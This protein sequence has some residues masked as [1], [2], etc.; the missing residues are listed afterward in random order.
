MVWNVTS[1]MLSLD[2]PV[3]A[4]R[5]L[6]LVVLPSPEAPQFGPLTASYLISLDIAA[7]GTLLDQTAVPELA[8]QVNGLSVTAGA[9]V[10]AGGT[11][12]WDF[13]G[14][15]GF[16]SEDQHSYAQPGK[17]DVGLRLVLDGR[18]AEYAGSIVVSRE[19]VV[20]A[21]LT[22]FPTFEAIDD[23]SVPAGFTRVRC[24]SNAEAGET[25]AVIWQRAGQSPI[26]GQ[27]VEFDLPPGRHTIAFAATRE[28]TARIYSQ[29]RFAPDDTLAMSALRLATN[30]VFELDGTETTGAQGNDPA[31]ELVTH[32]FGD[33]SISPVDRWTLELSLEDNEFLRSVSI[34]DN[35]QVDLDE[36]EDALLVLEYETL[37]T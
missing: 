3:G 32:L 12:L 13:G 28:L 16:R 34:N 9:T 29:Q 7:D 18:L 19:Q 36:I 2:A 5:N 14:G 15:D 27:Q 4:L 23:P 1:P 8:F 30:R 6:G 11:R 20:S 21:P 17:Y 37:L 22:A 35:E 26:R 24:T 10:P 25:L 31:N 33:G